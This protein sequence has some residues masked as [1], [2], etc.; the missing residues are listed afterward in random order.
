MWGIAAERLPLP[1]G[2]R[3]SELRLNLSQLDA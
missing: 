3:F 1:E 2:R